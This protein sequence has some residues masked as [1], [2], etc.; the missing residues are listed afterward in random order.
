MKG[1]CKDL[2]F[3]K[4]Q[5]LFAEQFPIGYV[6][7]EAYEHAMARRMIAK[8]LAYE[9]PGEKYGRRMYYLTEEGKKLI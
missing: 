6:G 9:S 1:N 8:G 7:C 4:A 5:K 2:V 3:T